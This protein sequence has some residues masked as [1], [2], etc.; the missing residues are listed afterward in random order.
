MKI[1]EA[2]DCI[3][4]KESI[5]TYTNKIYAASCLFLVSS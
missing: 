2:E 1:T 3:I 5:Y 4:F